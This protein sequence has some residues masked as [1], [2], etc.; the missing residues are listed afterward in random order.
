MGY[1]VRICPFIMVALASMAYLNADIF[2]ILKGN[3]DVLLIMDRDLVGLVLLLP[4][5]KQ[6]K[7]FLVQDFI[8]LTAYVHALHPV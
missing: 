7:Q 2:S 1:L 8:G 5:G 4:Y 3:V 6:I